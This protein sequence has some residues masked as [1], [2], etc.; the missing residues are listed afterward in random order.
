MARTR[1]GATRNATTRAATRREGPKMHFESALH[2]DPNIIPKGM[3]YAWVRMSTLN[4]PD[5]GNVNTKFRRGWRPVPADRHPE[6]Q[7]P[8]IPG[9]PRDEMHSAIV[10]EGGLMLCERPTADVQRDRETLRR[11]NMDAIEGIKWTGQGLEGTPTFDESSKVGFERV[12]A[13]LKG[14]SFKE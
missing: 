7:M 5:Q 12:T 1:T 10:N 8:E 14:P 11:D 6:L 3:T 9:M 13:E 4:E 2:I